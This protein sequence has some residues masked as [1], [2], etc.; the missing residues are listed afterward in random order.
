[1]SGIGCSE[2]PTDFWLSVIKNS[3]R[4]VTFS[5]REDRVRPAWWRSGNVE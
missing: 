1:M 3:L 4:A 2:S 5:S